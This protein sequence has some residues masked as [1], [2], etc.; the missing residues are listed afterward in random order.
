MKIKLWA[1]YSENFLI[2]H[3]LSVILHTYTHT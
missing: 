1:S 3:Y 2:N